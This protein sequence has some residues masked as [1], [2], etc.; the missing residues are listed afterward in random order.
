MRRQHRRVMQI[1]LF[2]YRLSFA[3]KMIIAFIMTK[4]NQIKTYL[5][6]FTIVRYKI[7]HI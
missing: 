5:V 6:A 1:E 4:K 2:F 7:V 3:N